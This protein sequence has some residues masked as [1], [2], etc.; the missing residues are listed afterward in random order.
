MRPNMKSVLKAFSFAQNG[1]FGLGEDLVTCLLKT[2]KHRRNALT[3]NA[4]RRQV[5]ELR[6]THAG[7]VPEAM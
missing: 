3:G 5:G 4:G 2:K 6:E 7:Q 1:C